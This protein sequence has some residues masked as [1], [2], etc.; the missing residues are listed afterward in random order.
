MI[1]LDGPVGTM[2]CLKPSPSKDFCVRVLNY[3]RFIIKIL[4][5]K[6]ELMK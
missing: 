3:L 5:D 6:I 4:E 1:S 2:S